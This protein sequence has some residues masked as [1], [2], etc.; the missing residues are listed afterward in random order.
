MN[1]EITSYIE[2]ITKKLNLTN[3]ANLNKV[4]LQITS[5][6][7]EMTIIN[8]G[9]PSM[10]IDL[11]NESDYLLIKM[12]KS[13]FFD[14]RDNK[15]HPEDLMFEEKIKIKGNLNLLR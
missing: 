5:D 2:T 11:E 3:K 14:L 4:H 12:E 9:N 8:L 10:E 13:T 6:N 7:E 1:K 15:K